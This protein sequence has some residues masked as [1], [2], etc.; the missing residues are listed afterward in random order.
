[1]MQKKQTVRTQQ[2]DGLFLR[3][4]ALMPQLQ[5]I[6]QQP[7][8]N[9]PHGHT[10]KHVK[11]APR[12]RLLKQGREQACAIAQAKKPQQRR[13]QCAD[14]KQVFVAQIQCTCHTADNHHGVEIH[15]RIQQ[16]QRKRNSDDFRHAYRTHTLIC[17][18][19]AAAAIR[20][21]PSAQNHTKNSTGKSK[22]RAASTN[23][24][25]T[26][27]HFAPQ[28][29]QSVRP[30]PKNHAIPLPTYC[31]HAIKKPPEAQA[32]GRFVFC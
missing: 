24:V 29:T 21:T 10:D 18:Q 4:S 1:M 8:A 11:H 32:F 9:Q 2:S 31:Y 25:S 23:P 16:R 14:L 28:S 26:Q 17:I 19:T 22:K 3:Q 20:R 7:C 30:T 15:V 5:G 6:F 13:A 12:F 27:R